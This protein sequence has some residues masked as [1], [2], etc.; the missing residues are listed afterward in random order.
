MAEY[1]IELTTAKCQSYGKCL[2][3]APAVF[4]WDRGRKVRL[5]DPGGAAAETVLKAAKLCPYRA[6]T[7]LDA[8]SGEQ[9]FPR[10]RHR[11]P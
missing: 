4:A 7:I 10:P 1:R 9:V 6:I 5:A 3:L 2:A 11:E 8:A